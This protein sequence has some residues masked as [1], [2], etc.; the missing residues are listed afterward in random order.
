[1][2]N[3]YTNAAKTHCPQGHEY[4]PENTFYNGDGHRS[5]RACRNEGNRRR[6]AAQRAARRAVREKAAAKRILGLPAD[7]FWSRVVI[8]DTG[9]RTPCL[10][11][12]GTISFAGYGQI[13]KSQQ[14]HYAHRYAYEAQAGLIP[15]AEPRL[16]LDHLCRVRPCVNTD[17]LELV[18][19]RTNVL[20]G[21]SFAAVNAA[22]T[23]C[24]RGHPF[25]PE[26]TR[27]DPTTGERICQECKLLRGRKYDAQRRRK[28]A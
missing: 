10:I 6:R 21:E 2:G 3:R 22:K 13:T 27:V 7:A 18:T 1:M 20:R 4:T 19:D 5:C 28:P 15:E 11:W 26:N 14:A 8:R 23:H 25:S 17:H 9:F 12:T 24:L 16:I